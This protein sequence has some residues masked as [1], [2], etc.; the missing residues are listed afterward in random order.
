[1]SSGRRR[2]EPNE[3]QL[4]R[5]RRDAKRQLRTRIGAIRRAVPGEARAARSR[6]IAAHVIAHEAF[7]NADVITAYVQMR[8]EVDPTPIVEAARAAGKTV[9]LPR[10]D[11]GE[12]SMR[13]F[14]W[15]AEAELEESGMGFL[16]PA[17]D[18]VAIADADV[19][20]VLTPALAIDLRGHRIGFG[21]G[22][23]DEFLRRLPNATS[24]ALIFDF[25]RLA[26]VP[27]TPGDVPVDFWAWDEGIDAAEAG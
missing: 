19:N 20:L 22:F 2:P 10:I 15:D 17:A 16:Q 9:A 14:A 27:D 5:L 11:W 18:A 12:E 6:K 23:Y 13:F 8:G 24:I 3:E 4:L 21:K 25:Q 26:E 1:M 7:V